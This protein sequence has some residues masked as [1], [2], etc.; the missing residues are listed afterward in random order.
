MVR[1][2]S[3]FSLSPFARRSFDLGAD[4]SDSF[5]GDFSAPAAN[6]RRGGEESH[7]IPSCCGFPSQVSRAA[8]ELY[9]EFTR[10]RIHRIMREPAHVRRAI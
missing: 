9:A 1:L 10:F 7:Y 8:F 2:R 4:F 6:C 3:H 5:P